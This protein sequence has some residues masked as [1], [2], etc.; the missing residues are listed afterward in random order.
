MNYLQLVD[1]TSALIVLGG[2]LLATLLRCGLR[3]SG[4]TLYAVV[5]I[6]ESGFDAAKARSR[7]AKQIQDI[8]D[9]GL[10]RAEIRDFD[11][12]EFDDLAATLFRRRSLAPVIDKHQKH[13]R[14]R[15][16]RNRSAVKTLGQ[17]A[18]MAPVLGLAGTLI[19][20]SQLP[21]GDSSGTTISS[22]IPAAIVTTFYGLMAAN[23]LFAPLGQFIQRRADKEEAERDELIKWLTD[24]LAREGVRHDTR[25]KLR[26]IPGDTSSPND[27]KFAA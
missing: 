10:L 17:A 26:G 19:A 14:K 2:T 18:E 4:A 27:R 5:T 15:L 21:M 25:Q 8:H 16:K 1:G 22:S 24:E 12:Q 6:F 3:D 23:M 11:D 7:L 9:D 20:L 13:Q